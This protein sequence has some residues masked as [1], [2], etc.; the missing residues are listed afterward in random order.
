M[1]LSGN[2]SRSRILLITRVTLFAEGMKAT[3][4]TDHGLELLHAEPRGSSLM[5]LCREHH[6]DIII[7]FLEYLPIETMGQARRLQNGHPRMRFMALLPSH[8]IMY[9][10]ALLE[11]GFHAVLPSDIQPHALIDALFELREGRTSCLAN[12]HVPT[13][14]NGSSPL[15]DREAQVVLLL[16]QGLRSD[17]V[18]RRLNIS[19]MTV[20]THRR[21]ILRKIGA[22]TTA[23]LMITAQQ[24]GIL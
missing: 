11:G 6:P 15:S 3:L 1:T 17:E 21:N 16:S 14:K 24:L 18:A 9:R 12:Q 13:V 10:N 5:D 8:L 4:A 2:P 23:E 19:I 7:V 22:R 20:N